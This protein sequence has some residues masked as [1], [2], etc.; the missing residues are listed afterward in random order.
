VISQ[1]P[2]PGTS[3]RPGQAVSLVTAKPAPKPSGRGGS[4][5]PGYSPCLP[6][7]SDYDCQGGEGDG[8]RFTGPV[9]VT[10]TDPYGLDD[11]GDHKG[12]ESS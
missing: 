6:P 11:D 10:G 5:T 1:S 12:C 8:P 9:T 2:D 7:A 3:A 4:C